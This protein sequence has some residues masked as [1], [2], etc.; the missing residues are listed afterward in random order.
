MHWFKQ[1][2][3]LRSRG[4]HR[5]VNFCDTER[6]ELQHYFNAWTDGQD[7]MD[8]ET[9]KLMLASL[10]LAKTPAEVQSFTVDVKDDQLSF[11]EFL[12]MIE[13]RLDQGTLQVLKQMLQDKLRDQA[14]DYKTIVAARRRQLIMD[15]TGAR[16]GVRISSKDGEQIMR[17]FGAL[18]TAQKGSR[19]LSRR[20][21]LQCQDIGT[22]PPVGEMGTMW[23]VVCQKNGLA[24][25]ADSA[26]TAEERRQQALVKPESPKSVLQ[27]ILSVPTPKA[28]G[29]RRMGKCKT[30]IVD[31]Q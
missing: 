19:K 28:D 11:E 10:N 23:E 4:K 16:Q 13:V 18:M 25:T 12:V 8:L 7:L 31:A 29:V 17:N 27:R 9:L 6:S 1:R 20:Q 24:P 2:A 30:I 21:S 3:W 14:L 22:V 5:Y 15:A 26:L